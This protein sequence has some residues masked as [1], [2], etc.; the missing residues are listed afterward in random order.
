MVDRK[1]K[2]TQVRQ[3]T[4]TNI[5]Q[6]FATGIVDE[7]RWS[8]SRKSLDIVMLPNDYNASV[9]YRVQYVQVVLMNT[10]TPRLLKPISLFLHI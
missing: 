1:A 6:S 9:L 8:R 2:D 4:T 10:E 3:K 7:P 5:I